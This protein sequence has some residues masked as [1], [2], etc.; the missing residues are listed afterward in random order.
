RGDR[1]GMLINNRVEWLEIFFAASR[2]GATVVPLS[3]WSTAAELEFLLADSRLR[4]LFSLDT[5]ADR[6]FVRI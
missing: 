1:V 6:A 3:T 4:V 5:W 2:V